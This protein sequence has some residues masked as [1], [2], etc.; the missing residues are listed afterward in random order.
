MK[1][2][3]CWRRIRRRRWSRPTRRSN[4]SS[5]RLGPDDLTTLRGDALKKQGRVADAEQ[6]YGEAIRLNADYFAHYLNRG[7]VRRQL[8]N[9]AGARADLEQANKLLPTAAGHYLLGHLDQEAGQRGRAIEHYKLAA[10]SN[11]EVGR[12]AG[13]AL[14]RLDLPGNPGDYV[15]V[16]A[17]A[18]GRG[19][20]GLRVT[21][22][23]PVAL[24]KL[25]V[26]GAVQKNSSANHF[27]KEYAVPGTLQPGQSTT[28]AMGVRLA[29]F[30]AQLKQV[31]AQVRGAEAAE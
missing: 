13:T 15:E 2:A 22:A 18:D 28:V 8:G 19:N 27:Y 10:G 24:R 17:V 29:D 16:E 1:A 25:R 9:S 14:V 23:S 11:S 3:S 26:A 20:L 6:E 30:N 31:R 21:N 7:L 12:L 5:V 4:W